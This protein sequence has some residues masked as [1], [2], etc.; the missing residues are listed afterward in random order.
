MAAFLTSS[1]FVITVDGICDFFDDGTNVDLFDDGAIVG[2]G[3]FDVVDV[4]VGV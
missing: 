4:N 2:S 1:F 3:I